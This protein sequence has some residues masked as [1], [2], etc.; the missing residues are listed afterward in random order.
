MTK[1]QLIKLLSTFITLMLCTVNSEKLSAQVNFSAPELIGRVTDNSITINTETDENLVYFFE[2]GSETGIYNGRFPAIGY[3]SSVANEPFEITINELNTN[4][5][6]YYRLVY[7]INNGIS[8]VERDEHSFQTQR[9]VGSDFIFTVI[10]DSHI[11]EEV[12]SSA[13]DLFTN[14]LDN[15]QRDNPDLH[16]DLGDTFSIGNVAIGDTNATQREYLSQRS[17]MGLISHSTPIYLMVGNHED[18][19]G[20]NLDD[21]GSDIASTRGIMSTNA[22]KKYFLNP[23]PTDFF[24]GN[25]NS[26]QIEIDDDHLRESYFAFE[27]G[28]ALFIGIDPYWNTM[29]KPFPGTSGGEEDDESVGDSW[30]WTLGEEQYLW[31][32]QTLETSDAKWKFVFSHQV[33]GGT[34]RYGRGGAEAT[35]DF[36]WGAD[37]LDFSLN[38][39]NWTFSTSIHQLMVNNGVTIFFHGHDHV[40]A[41]EEIDNMIY[42][43]CPQPTDLSYGSGFNS[44]QNSETTVVIENSGHLRIAVSPLE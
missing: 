23:I 4:S 34:V 2:Y 13:I 31:L 20:W 29:T 43:E 15:V 35:T 38:R 39:P 44:Y 18:E 17:N 14:T 25:T 36:E 37:E 7:S 21:A 30:D 33:V 41:K 28:D 11:G 8:W 26:N 42:Q 27:W 9:S 19:E 16:F 6:Y 24:S 32:K 12:N 40:F 5:R 10:S 3:L 22:R 1:K